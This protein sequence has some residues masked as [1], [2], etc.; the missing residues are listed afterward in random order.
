MI[1]NPFKKTWNP[2]KRFF[3]PDEIHMNETESFKFFDKPQPSQNKKG[4]KENR[5]NIIRSE[6]R[7][8]TSSCEQ[9]FEKTS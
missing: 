9:Y 7:E 2:Y 4:I 1:K 6:K 8:K 3:N 5:K